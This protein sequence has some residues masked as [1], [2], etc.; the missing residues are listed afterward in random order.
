MNILEKISILSAVISIIFGIGSFCYARKAKKSSNLARFYE[1][2]ANAISIGQLES[3]IY[4]NISQAR[5]QLEQALL[6]IASLK[7]DKNVSELNESEEQYLNILLKRKDSS[8]ENY[9]N[10]YEV[11]CG[12]FQDNKIDTVRFKKT[13]ADD[14]N[15]LCKK[16]AYKKQMHP[17][18]KSK[19]KSIWTVYHKWNQA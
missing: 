11:A 10:V 8:I 7:K 19:Y 6:E 15:N 12:L 1:A 14:I 4:N 2:R 3:S 5:N 18:S 16:D 17:E 9:L 13:Y